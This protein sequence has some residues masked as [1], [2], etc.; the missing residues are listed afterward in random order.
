[1]ASAPPILFISLKLLIANVQI[2]IFY[3]LPLTIFN[4]D[5]TIFAFAITFSR[6]GEKLPVLRF[7]APQ[8]LIFEYIKYTQNSDRKG[9]KP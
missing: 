2:I 6:G 7:T 1:M 5:L 9:S 8:S 3:L 4:I